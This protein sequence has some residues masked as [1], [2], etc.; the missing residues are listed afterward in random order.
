MEQVCCDLCGS[1]ET[2]YLYSKPDELFASDGEQFKVVQCVKCGLG[3]LDPRP[4]TAQ[5]AQYYPPQYGE[6]IAEIY[7]NSPQRLANR[8]KLLPEL[9]L[10]SAGKS[11][12]KPCLLDLGAGTGHFLKAAAEIGW[13]AHGLEPHLVGSADPPKYQHYRS[14]AEIDALPAASF[15]CITAWTVLEHLHSPLATFKSV[16]RALKPGG[17]FIFLTHNI[18]SLASRRLFIED[19]PR[20]LY[21]FSQVTLQKYCKHVGLSLIKLNCDNSITRMAPVNWLNY[22]LKYWLLGREFRWEDKQALETRQSYFQ[23]R[24]LKGNL[25]DQLQYCVTHPIQLLDRLLLPAVE[26][27]EIVTG[28]Y[29]VFVGVARKGD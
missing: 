15:D 11:E 18:N 6:M 16:S 12:E 3:F 7:R 27:I 24:D 9:K 23:R 29:A 14:M 13:A 10:A 21:F 19:I 8:V 2:R 1:A 20:H 22:I 4:A 25:K 28:R 17:S 26:Q 5:M